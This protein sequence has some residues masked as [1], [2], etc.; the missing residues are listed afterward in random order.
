[1][2]S[3]SLRHE[4]RSSRVPIALLA[5]AVVGG[6]SFAVQTL[7][8]LVVLS[9]LVAVGAT[10][11]MLVRPE[12]PVQV[13]LFTVYTNVAVVMAQQ[14]PLPGAVASG[15]GLLLAIPLV[16]TLAIE[17]KGLRLDAVFGLMLGLLGI[18][19]LS[20]AFAVDTAVAMSR[21]GTY[22]V[23]GL[24]I[25]F[26]FV[27][28]VRTLPTLRRVVMTL[29]AGGT[30]LSGITVYQAV[31]QSYDR[32]FGGLAQRGFGANAETFEEFQERLE[33]EDVTLEQ[34]TEM[35]SADRARGPVDD[36]N[37][38]A[39]ILLVVLPL[40]LFQF[41]HGRTVAGKAFG[42]G[43]GVLVLSGIILTYSRGAFLTLAVL[44]VLLVALGHI[45]PSKIVAGVLI[46]VVSVPLVAPGYYERIGS[47]SSVLDMFGESARVSEAAVTRGRTTE[48]LAALYAF[49]E[50]P[51]LGVGPGQYLPH[52]SVQ[53]QLR[54]EISFRYLPEPRRAHNLYTEFAA[55]TG[56][57]GLLVFLSIPGL[58]LWRLWKRRRALL[59]KRPDLAFL[60]TAFGLGILAYLG[61]GVFLHLA[62]ERYYW[63]FVAL[64]AAACHVLS[65]EI[66][67]RGVEMDE[68]R[69]ARRR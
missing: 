26:L 15:V 53:Y 3:E 27:N 47:I 37:R 41:R 9:G 1:M 2:A 59:P 60:A 12:L 45:R 64:T 13:V 33:Q 21:I 4:M 42:F 20:A 40:A 69:A 11:V 17:K 49:I 39:Q 52:Y 46:L 36:P 35:T 38:F 25:Y 44:T 58:L 29:L 55:E 50:H 31:T 61:T 8:A 68:S 7:D 32:D 51:V 66:A 6:M 22:A 62:F 56:L 28:T 54:P 19:L 18:F 23:E 10:L 5:L 30:L 67:T 43:A 65:G 48:T 14:G 24:A 63:L 16:H 57:P 34:V